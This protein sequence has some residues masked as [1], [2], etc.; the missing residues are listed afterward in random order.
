MNNLQKLEALPVEI[1]D[2]FRKT[3]KSLAINKDMQQYLRELEA[4]VQIKEVEKFDNMSRIARE[5]VKRYPQLPFRMARERVYDAYTFFHIS[6]AVS[7]DIWDSVYAD[8][9]EDLAKLCIAKGREEIAFKAFEKA[10]EYRTKSESRIRPEDLKA[11]V[12][13]ISLNIKPEDLGYEKANLKE[14]ARKD[15]EGHY[16]KLINSLNTNEEEKKRLR[17]D[18]GITDAEIVEDNDE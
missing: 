18:A 7:N 16:V 1:I 14:I 12:F 10:H 4:V 2:E 8:K 17:N 5:L 15:N 6:D 3:G 11:P 13:I 9:M